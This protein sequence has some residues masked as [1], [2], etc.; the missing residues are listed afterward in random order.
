MRIEKL[1]LGERSYN[2]YIG[3]GLLAEVG[4]YL[5]EVVPAKKA[6]LIS[7]ET[8]YSLYG[9]KVEQSLHEHGYQVTGYIVKPGEGSKSLKVASEIYDLL[10]EANIERSHPLVALGGGVVGDLTGFVAGTWQRGVPFIQVPTTLEAAID[11]SV[12]GKTAVNHPKGKNMIGVFNQPKMVLMDIET[13]STLS[14]RDIR[15]GLAESIKHAVIRDSA[16]FD[17]HEKYV[18]EILALEPTIVEPLLGMN[19]RIK[20]DVVSEDEREGGLRAILNFGHTIGHAI[21]TAGGM[22][23]WRHGEAV[24]L[25]MVGAG[26]IAVARGKFSIEEFQRMEK[27]IGEFELPTRY[28]DLEFDELYDFMKRDKKVKAGKIRFVL[29]VRIGET[30]IVDDVTEI[31]MAEA[32][33]YLKR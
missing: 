10:Y 26:F 21:E 32:V 13:L 29:P 33:E 4:K 16:L 12:G 24:A 23:Q 18:K 9:K 11:A 6:V 25:G 15:S 31:Q 20:A 14:V 17:Y 8:V 1:N 7:D 3:A 30:E 2:I 28:P 19:C 27:L 5:R 22:K